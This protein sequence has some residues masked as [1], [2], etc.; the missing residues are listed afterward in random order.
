MLL[1]A[2]AESGTNGVQLTTANSGFDVVNNGTTGSTFFDAAHAISGSLAYKT[3]AGSGNAYVAWS[4]QLGGTPA[5]LY[6]RMYARVDA[7]YNGGLFYLRSG[8]NRAGNASLNTNGHILLQNGA[9]TTLATSTSAVAVGTPFRIELHAI[10]GA[11]TTSGTLELRIFLGMDNATPTETL[12]PFTATQTATNFDQVWYGPIGGGGTS[13]VLYH[14]D[15]AAADSG[16]IGPANT[17]TSPPSASTSPSKPSGATTVGST[18]QVTDNG[19]WNGNPAPTFTYQWRRCDASGNNA[20]D[21]AGATDRFYTV[22]DNDLGSTLRIAVKATNTWGFSTAASVPTAVVTEPAITSIALINNA[23][24]PNGTAVSNG[25]SG[26]GLGSAWDIVNAGTGSITYDTTDRAHGLA[27]LK[28]Q[29]G[30]ANTY[31]AWSASLGTQTAIYGRVY[32]KLT[33]YP[34]NG[35]SV[36]RL[37]SGGSLAASINITSDGILRVRDASN[38]TV[39]TSTTAVTLYKWVRLEWHAV[40]STTTGSIELRYYSADDSTTPTEVIQT[41]ANTALAAN[42]DTVIFGNYN[43]TA[44]DL[45]WMDELATDNDWIGPAAAAAPRWGW[46]MVATPGLVYTG[47]AGSGSG[48]AAKDVIWGMNLSNGNAYYGTTET[49]TQMA[50]R[51]TASFGN[52]GM[53]KTYHGSLTTFDMTLEGQNPNKR[54]IVCFKYDQIELASGAHDA[55]L[56]GYVRSI[57]AGWYVILVNWQEPDN[58]ML[59]SSA[60]FT[61]AQHVAA[62]NHVAALVHAEIAAGRLAAGVTCEVWDNFMFSTIRFGTQGVGWDDSYLALQT[63]GVAWDIYGNPPPGARVD[64][65]AGG[66]TPITGSTYGV[67]STTYNPITYVEDCRRIAARNNFTKWGFFEIGAPFR[68]GDVQTTTGMPDGYYRAQWFSTIFDALIGKGAMCGLVFD[69]MGNGFDQRL[70]DKDATAFTGNYTLL[71]GANWNPSPRPTPNEEPAVTT[72]RSYFTKT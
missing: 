64:K 63:D 9:G 24:G 26:G 41:P 20:V 27:S 46:G 50:A 33:G 55:E 13:G 66:R 71:S 54:A 6:L 45:L 51:Q 30:G 25:N 14:D 31:V 65:T 35:A 49:A 23:D 44:G 47:D 5:E 67:G 2:N 3:T 61:P 53:S 36:I 16:W 12:G 48:R 15:D 37:T 38:S 39:V 19:T 68:Q 69:N 57:P 43:G 70:I 62:S 8:G 40:M 22:T 4:T 17:P 10:A 34:L 28:F 72:I 32:L 11:T 59:G 56:Q 29:A 58:D 60:I 7:F 18:L 21:I 42:L 1:N 52:I